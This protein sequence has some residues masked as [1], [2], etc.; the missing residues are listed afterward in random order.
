MLANG[1][2]N[3]AAKVEKYKAGLKKKIVAANRELAEVK[4]KFKTN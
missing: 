3:V 4:Y 1:D 2:E